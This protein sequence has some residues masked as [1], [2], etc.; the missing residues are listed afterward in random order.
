MAECKSVC[1]GLNQVIL[2][3]LDG[4]GPSADCTPLLH[5]MLR[6]LALRDLT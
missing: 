6:A 1:M 3:K 5:F 4:A 2:D